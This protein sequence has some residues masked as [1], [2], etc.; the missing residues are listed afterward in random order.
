MRVDI[1]I[2][3][4]VVVSLLE[5]ERD[6]VFKILMQDI[7]REEYPRKH[8]VGNVFDGVELFN[9]LNKIIQHY[10]GSAI[11]YE[12]AYEINEGKKKFKVHD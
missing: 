12:A 2:P 3:D 5:D 9:A 10:G 8:N 4:D 6:S 11:S 1:N 7:V